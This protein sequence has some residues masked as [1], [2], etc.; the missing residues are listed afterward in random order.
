VRAAV[1]HEIGGRL[2]V[3]EVPEPDQPAVVVRAAG[4]SFADALMRRGQYP[5]M[6]ELPFV[7]GSE[8]AGE[9]EGRRVM[10]F[11]RDTGGGYAERA[12]VD[13]KWIFDLPRDASFAEGAGFLLGFLTVWIPLTRQL[14]SIA[15]RTVLVH[16]AAGGV[17][18]AAVQL[19]RHLGA[20]VIGTASTEEKR[21]FVRELGAERVYDYETF[22]DNVKADIIVDP[23]GGG[24][25]ARSLSALEPLGAIV[26]IGYA[27]GPWQE[28]NP[29]L[30][31]GRNVSVVGF[32]LGR[33]MRLRPEAV[34][35]AAAEVIE[36]WRA[37]VVKPI[38]G[39]EYS[40]EDATDAVDALESRRTIGKV[41]L[42]P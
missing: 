40:L 30:I 41:V 19:A 18:S 26:A 36:L 16:A 21:A 39:G 12:A 42:V 9:L 33:L 15:G 10:G 24:V 22:G 7:P 20:R 17:G 11:V 37:G 29:A 13:P 25:F 35:T 23:V 5:Q 6:P 32:Y 2:R 31:V 34:R 8:I 4:V 28:V 27:A 3:E 1:L 38:V 14:P